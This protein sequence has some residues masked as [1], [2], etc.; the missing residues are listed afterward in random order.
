MSSTQSPAPPSI[1]SQQL[2]AELQSE[3]LAWLTHLQQQHQQQQLQLVDPSLLSPATSIPISLVPLSRAPNG[4]VFNDVSPIGQTNG[5]V[6]YG[7][8]DTAGVEDSGEDEQFTDRYSLNLA[9]GVA[10]DNRQQVQARRKEV[11]TFAI[12]AY[13]VLLDKPYSNWSPKAWRLLVNSI[14]KEFKQRH[15]WSREVTEAV[16]KKIC[17]DTARNSRASAKRAAARAGANVPQPPTN[18]QPSDLKLLKEK[19]L[20]RQPSRQ[21]PPGSSLNAPYSILGRSSVPTPFQAVVPAAMAPITT[22]DMQA[23]PYQEP[24]VTEVELL[25]LYGASLGNNIRILIWNAGFISWDRGKKFDIFKTLLATHLP[26][27]V[28]KSL[29]YYG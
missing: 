6:P 15:G 2:P 28:D 4:S 14:A 12:V 7:S 20:L 11:S 3:F 16:M 29:I 26:L 1:P 9:M 5:D 19:R 27:P 24:K 13:N 8:T 18:K 10:P 17:S 23:V 25:E 21:K 22:T